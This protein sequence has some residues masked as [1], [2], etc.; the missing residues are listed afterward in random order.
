MTVFVIVDGH[1]PIKKTL[2]EMSYADVNVIRI[3]NCLKYSQNETD[4]FENILDKKGIMAYRKI[5]CRKIIT[6]QSKLQNNEEN[7]Y[8]IIL[9]R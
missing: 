1:L 9:T 6:L 3:T 7:N 5:Y 2:F 4:L 8:V